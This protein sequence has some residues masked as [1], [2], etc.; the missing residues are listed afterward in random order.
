MARSKKALREALS[1]SKTTRATKNEAQRRKSNISNKNEKTS[2]KKVVK[3]TI[4]NVSSAKGNEIKNKKKN[5]QNLEN[6]KKKE[7]E[8]TVEDVF[9]CGKCN[10]VM[11]ANTQAMCCDVCECWVHLSCIK[12][13]SELYRMIKKCSSDIKGLLWLCDK[14]KEKFDRFSNQLIS[15]NNDLDLNYSSEDISNEIN[16]IDSFEKQL[17]SIYSEINNLKRRPRPSDG[18]EEGSSA[19]KKSKASLQEINLPQSSSKKESN[20][21]KENTSNK[22]KENRVSKNKR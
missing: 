12:M 9:I 1:A 17:Q 22:S 18:I 11:K 21:P 3:K 15:I 2:S 6:K 20:R 4:T 19:S 5:E 14:C 13:P 16:D 7:A 8:E 10:E